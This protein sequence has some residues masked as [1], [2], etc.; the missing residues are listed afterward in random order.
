[1]REEKKK[2]SH[3]YRVLWSV[4]QMISPLPAVVFYWCQISFTKIRWLFNSLI[5]IWNPNSLPCSLYDSNGFGSLNSSFFFGMILAQHD[6]WY[7]FAM[8]QFGLFFTSWACIFS[9]FL[10]CFSFNFSQSI[11]FPMPDNIGIFFFI[12]THAVQCSMFMK[13]HLFFWQ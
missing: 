4:L 3:L 1:M 5:L 6:T 7:W 8:Y 11:V 9:S 2:V 10:S 12:I 13:V